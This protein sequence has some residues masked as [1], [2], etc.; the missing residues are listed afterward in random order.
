M[1]LL[2]HAY[3]LETYGLRLGVKELAKVI[4]CAPA[5][6]HNQVSAGTFPVKTYVDQNKR[7]ADYRDVA[8]YMDSVRERAA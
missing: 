1:S 5:T 4:G 2:T 7:W 8:E 3:L 6:V